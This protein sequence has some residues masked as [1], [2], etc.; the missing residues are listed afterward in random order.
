MKRRHLFDHG[1]PVA[2][3]TRIAGSEV[4]LAIG[5][6][7]LRLSKERLVRSHVTLVNAGLCLLQARSKGLQPALTHSALPD[8]GVAALPQLRE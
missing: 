4:L 8:A 2:H 6:Q 5:R 3:F 7:S 1:Y